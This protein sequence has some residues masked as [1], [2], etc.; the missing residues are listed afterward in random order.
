M[1]CMHLI[2]IWIML[3]LS[4]LMSLFSLFPF[5]L[6]CHDYT[7]HDPDCDYCLASDHAFPSSTL[8]NFFFLWVFFLF[9]QREYPVWLMPIHSFAHYTL[10]M[11]YP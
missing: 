1:V 5:V 11:M 6:S 7:T 3:A 8:E 9:F 2:S 4:R 10:P